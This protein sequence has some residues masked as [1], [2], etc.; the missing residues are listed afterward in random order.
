MQES[1]AVFAERGAAVNVNFLPFQIV[2]A[3]V[4]Q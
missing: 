2:N 1:G 3:M 4:R